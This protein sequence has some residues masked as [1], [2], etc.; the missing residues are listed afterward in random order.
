MEDLLSKLLG[1]LGINNKI[2]SPNASETS[3]TPTV[4]NPIHVSPSNPIPSPVVYHATIGPNFMPLSPYYYIRAK[5]MYGWNLVFRK[6]K[7]GYNSSDEESVGVGLEGIRVD[8]ENVNS[9]MNDSDIEKVSESIFAQGDK[10]MHKPK[11][12]LDKVERDKEDVYS[13]RVTGIQKENRQEG[14]YILHLIEE[15]VKVG[16]TMGYNKD[17]CIENMEA[18]IG[19]AKKRWVK[20]LCSKN[21]VNFVALQETNMEYVDLLTLR[22]L[23]RNYAFEYA[24]SPSLGN[25]SGILC[26]WESSMFVKENVSISDSFLAIT[27]TWVSTATRLLIISMYV[28]Q[29]LVEK[30]LLWEYLCHIK[31]R[32]DG[33]CIILGDFNEVRIEDE[34]FAI[35][36]DRHLSGHRP[37]LLKKVHSDYGAIPFHMFN[38]W[39][40]MDGF[41]KMTRNKLIEINRVLD[42]GGTNT[43]ILKQRMELV[44]SLNDLESL[45]AMDITQKANVR[46]S[47]EG[48]E[49][50]K[51]FHMQV[52]HAFFSHFADQFNKSKLFQLHLEAQFPNVL[53]MDQVAEL[54]RNVSDE[55]IKRAIWDCGASK[56]PGPDGYTFE[57]FRRYWNFIEQDIL[58]GP[59]ILNELISWCKSK[60]NKA[61]VFKVDFEKAYESIRWDYLNDILHD[62]VFIMEWNDS[63]L[64]TIVHV[65]KSFF[66]ASSLKINIHKSKLIG[67]GVRSDEMDRA[68]KVVGCSTLST[69]FSYLRVTIGGRMSRIQTWDVVVH[70]V[71][72]KMGYISWDKVLISKKKGGLR[73]SSYFAL[74]RALLFKWVWRFVSQDSS[75]WS[76]CIQAIH[77]IQGALDRPI[78]I[79]CHSSWLDIIKEVNVLRSK[80]TSLLFFSFRRVPMGGIKADQYDELSSRLGSIRLVQMNDRWV[81]SLTGSGDLSVKS[82]R[83]LLDD[84]LL[85]SNS[86]PTRWVKVIPNKIN[87]FAWKVQKDRLP[88]RLNLSWLGIDI[89]SLSCPIYDSGVESLAHLLFDYPLVRAVLAKVRRCWGFSSQEFDSY[90]DWFTWFADILLCRKTNSNTVVTSCFEIIHSDVWTSPILSPSGFKYYVLFLDHYSQF[91]WVYP[92]LNKSDVWSKFL[93]FR[94][95]VRTQFKCEIRS[96]QCDHGGEFDNRHFHKLFADN[97]IQF[98]FSC[99]KTS[100][101][102]DGTLSRY[103]ARLVANGSTRLE[104]VDVDETFSLIVKPGTIRAVLSLAASRHWRIHQLDRSLYGLKQAPRAWFQRFESYITRVGFSHSRCNSSLFIYRQRIDTAYLLPYVDD[105]VLTASSKHLLQQKKYAIEILDRAHMVNCNPIRTPID[106]ESKLGSDGDPVSDPTLDRSLACSLQYLTFTRLDISYAVQ[107]VCLY[108]HDPR[109]PHFLALKRILRYV[110]GT[111][112]YELQ[113]F[114]SSTTNLVAYSDADWAGCLTTRRSTLGYCVFLGNNLLSWSSK[115]QPTLSRSSAEAEYR[116]VAN[117]VAETCW[118]RNLLRELHTPLSFATLVY[119]D[120]VWVLHVSSRYQFANIFTKGL[121]SALFEEFRSSLNVWCPPA[122]TAKECTSAKQLWDICEQY[123]KVVDSFIPARISKEGKK[124]CLCTI[125]QTR[126]QRGQNNEGVKNVEQ[127]HHVRVNVPFSSSF[128]RSFVAPVSNDARHHKNEM[129]IEDKPVMVIDE[130]CVSDKNSELTLV[131]KVKTYLGGFWVSLEFTDIHARD[132]FKRHEGMDTWFSVI[133]QW[134]NDFRMDERVLWI[135]VEGIP[136]IAWTNTTSMKIA[137]RWGEL[138][139]TKHSDDNNLWRKRLCVVTKVE[140]Y[141]ME[142]FKIIIKGRVT[143]IRA[144]EIIGW[145]LDFIEEENE[146]SSYSGDEE[147]EKSTPYTDICS[148]VNGIGSSESDGKGDIDNNNNNGDVGEVKSDDPS[149]I[150]NLLNHK[151]KNKERES[152]VS[153]DPSK[154]PGFSKFIV[155]DNIASKKE[156]GQVNINDSIQETFS[157]RLLVCA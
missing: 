90:E 147:S 46:W 151:D 93:K 154:P 20:E 137:K 129:L 81:W 91:V 28:P 132:S 16:Q 152:L 135:D 102:N 13:Q 69:P 97:G 113:L 71:N 44:K 119:C 24:I 61:M 75:L 60:K 156:D 49:N 40:Q 108:M 7:Y 26:V 51:F 57:F 153:E 30:R 128:S 38:S 68:A 73:V 34:R 125:Y 109:E 18:I 110:R 32:W 139:F 114:S 123:G 89:P 19:C 35:C 53:F 86:L 10:S 37:I 29:E 23:W 131:A 8:K 120:N 101:Q 48:D 134:K 3:K 31:G 52:K 27:G 88:C 45:E 115:R 70:G 83:N 104:G 56:S 54:E 87:V 111:L 79:S 80:G 64:N 12:V 99:P 96:F 21:R 130:D 150:Y 127:K 121:P 22:S 94:T 25:S 155:E 1:Q 95:Y 105:I 59:F 133:Q 82:I 143:V 43:N 103:K 145:I 33:E 141:I 140:D 39:F 50:T 14:E 157:K 63:N 47:I 98:H 136:L 55:E 118:L 112:D 122:P 62:V 124:I 65:L 117:A 66:L 72:R 11:E 74:N 67:I 85:S 92:L 78:K 6:D 76:R 5:E 58:D 142:S 15:L 144:R 17:G 77:G 36:L 138:V 2:S 126:F 116:G 149:G 84:S 100:Q 106:T 146:T 42:Q 41:D 148:G 9:K 107:Q 4:T